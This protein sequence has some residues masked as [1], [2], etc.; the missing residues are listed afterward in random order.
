MHAFFR[1]EIWEQLDPLVPR[2]ASRPGGRWRD[3]RQVVEGILYRHWAGCSWREVPES[4]GPWQTLWRREQRWRR[5]GTLEAIISKADECREALAQS[6][7]STSSR[8]ARVQAAEDWNHI[9]RGPIARVYLA[10][11]Y[12]LALDTVD[13]CKRIFANAPPAPQGQPNYIRFDRKLHTDIASVLIN[14][15]RIKKMAHVGSRASSERELHS[16]QARRIRWLDEALD[17]L[18]TGEIFKWETG[19]AL[20]SLDADVDRLG[21]KLARAKITKPTLILLDAVLG[22]DGPWDPTSDG[23]IV[24]PLR[25]YLAK[26]RTFVS[27]RR[28][29]INLAKIADQCEAIAQRLASNNSWLVQGEDFSSQDHDPAVLLLAPF[30]RKDVPN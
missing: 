8:E 5:D 6:A 20:E 13:I 18:S 12:W 11:V 30:Y 10:E 21:A 4:F 17:G 24:Y 27:H 9:R 22:R 3:H 23:A 28:H 26:E 2:T 19:N 1:D 15:G 29:K 16:V 7:P 14:A 25:I